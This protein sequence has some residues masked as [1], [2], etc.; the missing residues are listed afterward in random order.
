MRY[1]VKTESRKLGEKCW[2]QFLICWVWKAKWTVCL[3]VSSEILAIYSFIPKL[4]LNASLC[5]ALNTKLSV[6]SKLLCKRDKELTHINNVLLKMLT[7]L[8]S[9][10]CSELWGTCRGVLGWIHLALEMALTSVNHS[11]NV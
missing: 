2:I 4:F 3:T 5:Q 1:E 10:L 6:P 8:V 9:L 7:I 11:S